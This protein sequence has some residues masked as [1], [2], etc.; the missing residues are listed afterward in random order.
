MS[1]KQR[2][3]VCKSSKNI[4][5]SDAD[6]PLSEPD[7]SSQVKRWRSRCRDL[8]TVRLFDEA[9]SSLASKENRLN[10]PHCDGY[11]PKYKACHLRFTQGIAVFYRYEGA[12]L[13]IVAVMQHTGDKNDYKFI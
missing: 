4:S 10:R 12:N 13:F 7:F 5:K 1:K 9:V 8:L 3:S 11:Y 2:I 6:V